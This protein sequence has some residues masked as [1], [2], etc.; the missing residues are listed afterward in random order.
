MA[1]DLPE[2]PDARDRPRVGVDEWVAQVEG[3]RERA[4][5]LSG[6]VWQIWERLPPFGR[7]ALFVVPAALLPPVVVAIAFIALARAAIR[8]TDGGVKRVPPEDRDDDS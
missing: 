1:E 4:G 3:R 2:R 7:L 5:G 6:I 8:H